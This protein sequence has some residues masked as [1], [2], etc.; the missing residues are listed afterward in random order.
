MQFIQDFDLFR[1]KIAI[2]YNKSIEF[3]N[4]WKF[5]I[6]NHSKNKLLKNI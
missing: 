5:T 6:I 4:E 3:F 2:N 1:Y